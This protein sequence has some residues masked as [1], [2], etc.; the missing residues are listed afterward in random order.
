MRAAFSQ[1][2]TNYD[3]TLRFIVE[4]VREFFEPDDPTEDS[5]GTTQQPPKRRTELFGPGLY[6]ECKAEYTAD[7]QPCGMACRLFAGATPYAGP[8]TWSISGE[9]LRGDTQYFQYSLT[10]TFVPSM[11]TG[12]REALSKVAHWDQSTTLREENALSITATVR[13]REGPCLPPDRSSAVS[14]MTLTQSHPSNLRFEAYQA[15]RSSGQLTRPHALFANTEIIGEACPRLAK[16]RFAP[17]CR[18]SFNGPIDFDKRTD[19]KHPRKDRYN[20]PGLFS[21][22]VWLPNAIHSSEHD[23]GSDFEEDDAAEST[24]SFETPDLDDGHDSIVSQDSEPE[25]M[26][27]VQ[28]ALLAISCVWKVSNS[29]PASEDPLEN[30]PQCCSTSTSPLPDNWEW[31]FDESKSTD[32]GIVSSLTVSS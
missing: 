27:D 7:G 1:I 16:C 3:I 12:W 9:S 25:E 8:I 5:L 4:D 19:V 29:S 31:S 15:R 21:G 14:Y 23:D 28:G 17:T 6:I 13:A 18:C 2:S 30:E 32:E 11:G 24:A 26:E 22:D 10:H 20:L